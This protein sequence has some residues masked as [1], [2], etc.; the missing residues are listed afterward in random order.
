MKAASKEKIFCDVLVAGGGVSGT[1]AAL[2]AAR[3]GAHT[4]LMKK[5]MSWA[6]QVISGCYILCAVYT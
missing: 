6:E 1:A 5:K 4:V 3:G 2:A